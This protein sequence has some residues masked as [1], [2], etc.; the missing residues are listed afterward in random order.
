M[1]APKL[2]HAWLSKQSAET[3]C[4]AYDRLLERARRNGVTYSERRRR[5][6]KA[7]RVRNELERRG[8]I[9]PVMVELAALA[10]AVQP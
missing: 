9:L 2:T 4:D 6:A 8:L 5:F 3:L 7:L 10:K 1:N